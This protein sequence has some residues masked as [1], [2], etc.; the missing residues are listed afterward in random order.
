MIRSALIA[1]ASA[2]A[3]ALSTP[4]FAEEIAEGASAPEMTFGTW[5]FDPASLDPSIAPGDDFFAYVNGKW[6]RDNPIPP[7]FSRYGAFTYLDEKSKEDVRTLIDELV[8][9]KHKPGSKEQRLVDAYEAYLDVAAINAK[10][11]S[12][13]YPYLTKIF[14]APDLAAL[15]ELFGDPAYPSLV[16]AGVTIDDK[17]PDS[18]IPSMGFDGMGLPDRDIYLVDTPKNEETRAKYKD[19]LAFMLGKAGYADATGA[20]AAVYEFEHKVAELEWARTALRN[21][22]LTYHKLTRAEVA[23]LA[24]N[25][26]V[27]RT[28]DAAGLGEV[29]YF[30]APQIPPGAEKAKEL[31]LDEATLAGIGGGLPAMMELL[32]E[33]PLATIKAFMV[34]KYL[35]RYA[36]VLPSD[37]DQ[38]RFDFYSKTLNGVEQQQP[39]WKRAI[40]T[41]ESQLGEVLGKAYSER[42][43]PASSKV[44]ME[45]LVGNLRKALA[46][47]LAENDWMGADTKVQAEAKLASFFPKI[48]YPDKFEEYAGLEISGTDPLGNAVSSARWQQ[49]KDISRLGGP[50]DREEWFMLPQEV[51]AYYNPS[52]NEIVFPAAILQQPFFGPDVDP[53]VNYGA[54]G[55]VIGH[56]MGHGFDDQGSKFSA[57]GKLENWWTDADRAAFDAKGDMLAAQYSE[58]CPFDEGKTCVNGR[59]SLGENIGDLSGLSLAYRAYRMSL[60]G[61]EAPV[62]D[63]LTGDQRFFLA[64][65]QVWRSVSREDALRQRLM[66]GPHSPEMYRVIGPLRNID[67]WYKAFNVTPDDKMYL[68]PE[69][70][71]HIW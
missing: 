29:E 28:L 21:A 67:A 49:K 27:L 66:T 43:F 60:D 63:G 41:T 30:L 56:E 61:K 31:G 35:T 52:F 42:Y 46:A 16:S 12:P 2:V 9:R 15:A 50:M 62:I 45:E 4:A 7:E 53:A 36:G 69:K 25:Y 65:A 26:P 47:S 23:A 40:D 13:A 39:R 6:V 48:G 51:N 5:G 44:E 22:D 1:G 55:G 54:I 24:P 37:I 3:L 17:D 11:L 14:E 70:R 8:A 58:F 64:W 18:Y 38:A 32:T 59:L 20:A 33:T 71:V 34:T 10:G 57:S 19:Y 68:P